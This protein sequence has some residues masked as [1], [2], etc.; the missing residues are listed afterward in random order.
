LA[1]YPSTPQMFYPKSFPC[2]EDEVLITHYNKSVSFLQDLWFGWWYWGK[3]I[4]NEPHFSQ[5]MFHFDYRVGDF[6]LL[7][8]L[9]GAIWVSHQP[10]AGVSDPFSLITCYRNM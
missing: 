3:Q 4:T 7:S 6:D 1:K 2:S 10:Q 8:V 9:L 5:G